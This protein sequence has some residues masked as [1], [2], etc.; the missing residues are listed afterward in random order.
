MTY[1]DRFVAYITFVTF[2]RL[3]FT[4]RI[5]IGEFMNKIKLRLLLPLLSLILV[6]STMIYLNYINYEDDYNLKIGASY[7]T[8]NNTFYPVINNEI[9]KVIDNN[10]D[11]LYTRDATLD[12]TKQAQQ[13]LDLINLDIDVLIVTPVDSTLILDSLQIAKSHDIKVIVLDVP[14]ESDDYV[15]C[16]IVSDNYD[17]GVQ[18]A[19]NL[20]NR[21]DKASIV[22]LEHNSVQSA[23]DRINGF[24]DT[25]AQDNNYQIVIEADC[26]GQTD[27]AFPV[28]NE[29]ISAGYQFDTVMALN[30]PSA[31]GT[32][33]AIEENSLTTDI[34]VYGVD[35]SPDLKQLIGHNENIQGTVS[36]SPITMGKLAIQTAYDM[37]NGNDY[38]S[39]I[40]VPVTMITEENIDEY[41]VSGWQ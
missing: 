27:K 9:K 37:V 31:L 22:L 38:E 29:I 6:C 1:Y 26:Q 13:I 28:M 10:S 33:A 34:I 4:C 24:V 15:D 23:V 11:K 41:D 20:M 3:V 17:A 19:K 25:I 5:E 30:D 18:C 8:M 16:T 7:M 21:V 32:L 12:A 2:T 39:S 36:Q 40:V 14:V 35:G